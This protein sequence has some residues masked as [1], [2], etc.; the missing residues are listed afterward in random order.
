[1]INYKL[2]CDFCESFDSKSEE[3]HVNDHQTKKTFEDILLA[4]KNLGYECEIYG[5]IPEL[6]HAYENNKKFSPD[7]IFINLSDGT[8]HR[9]SRVQVP[10]LC[11]LLNLNY[12][13][14][15]TFELALTSNKYY[16]SMAVK[17]AGILTPQGML[18][19]NPEDLF[20]IPNKKS[21][22]KP[23]SEGSSL[24]ITNKSVCDEVK[25]IREQ[26]NRL[27]KKFS[28]ILIEE[29]IPG[30]D[31]TCFVIG[32]NQ[33]LLNEALVVKHHGKLLFENEVLGYK[34]HMLGTRTFL[35]ADTVLSR[36][37]EKRVKNISVNIK[38]LFNIY[39]FCRIDYRV[40][41]DSKIYFLEINT[42]PAISLDSQ[43]GV[44]CQKL[45]IS[46]ENFID[47]IICTVTNRFSHA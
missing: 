15:G 42:V 46:F 37:T 30:Y 9:Y 20:S 21:I 32:N 45:N 18:V 7:T 1:M 43:V 3:G 44:I 14:G 36:E 13:G 2:I 24:G 22:I 16:S 35:P 19:T 25:E 4:I 8:N 41:K 17:D 40:T 5:G 38:N 12:S 26:S 34:E 27:L 28:E 29:Y 10:V 6:I 23:N 33:I 31:V 47:R 39:D 11:D